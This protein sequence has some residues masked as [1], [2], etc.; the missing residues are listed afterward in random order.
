MDST[1]GYHLLF[2]KVFNIITRITGRPVHFDH[3]HLAG[4]HGIIVDMDT[5]QYTGKCLSSTMAVPTNCLGL[6]KYLQEI[7]PGHRDWRWQLQHIIVFC[8]IHFQRTILRTIGTQSKGSGVYQRMM[9]LLGCQSEEEYDGH[10]DLII[11]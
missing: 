11:G 5:K 1:E 2:K 8:H 4:I 10:L 7:D 9:G 3:I 6:G